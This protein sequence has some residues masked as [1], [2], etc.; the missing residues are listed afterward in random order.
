MSVKGNYL[1]DRMRV[2][3][4][5]LRPTPHLPPPLGKTLT[6]FE[7]LQVAA[8]HEAG[9]SRFGDGELT[10]ALLKRGIPFQEYDPRLGE[11]LNEALISGNPRVL[12]CL[13]LDFMNTEK[14][15][16]VRRY[17]RP[18]TRYDGCETV[19][20]QDDVGVVWRR[21][22]SRKYRA[23]H[24]IVAE[25]SARKLWGE[26]TVFF[27]GLYRD[28]YQ[29]NRLNDV[30]NLMLDFISGSGALFVAPAHPLM[31]PS[32]QEL[33]IRMPSRVRG[34]FISIPERNSFR[35]Y[36]EIKKAVLSRRAVE[37]VYIQAGPT[38]TALAYDLS[39][40]HGIPAY[41]VGS[42]NVA[43]AAVGDELRNFE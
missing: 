17:G 22:W 34:S 6:R 42:L 23:L 4:A 12:V 38:A 20:Q 31:A 24:A 10:L 29:A 9:L 41:D 15:R 32:F 21:N 13:N 33:S 39:V 37:R 3:L 27:L 1:L 35:E 36:A 8:N 11:L 18:S 16:W 19:R 2:R 30:A 7:T 40:N 14:V 25:R 43:L 26:A 28:E 5:P